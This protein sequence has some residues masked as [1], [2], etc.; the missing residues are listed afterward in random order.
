MLELEV[1]LEIQIIEEGDLIL[2]CMYRFL[3]DSKKSV[4]TLE[5]V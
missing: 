4:R 5:I 3:L 2:F 1:S